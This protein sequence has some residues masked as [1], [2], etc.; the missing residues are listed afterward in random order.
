MRTV[1][2]PSAIAAPVAPEGLARLYRGLPDRDAAAALTCLA[3]DLQRDLE[4][5]ETVVPAHHGR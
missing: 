3:Q 2:R 1:D 4:R 5:P